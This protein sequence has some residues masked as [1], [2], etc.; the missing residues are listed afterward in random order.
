VRNHAWALVLRRN[1][2]LERRTTPPIPG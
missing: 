1:N 2:E